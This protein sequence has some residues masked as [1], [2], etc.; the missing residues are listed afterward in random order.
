MGWHGNHCWR[1][2]Y[3]YSKAND[4]DGCLIE[5]A[6]AREHTFPQTKAN[7]NDELNQEVNNVVWANVTAGLEYAPQ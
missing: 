4:R 2:S 5:A 3:L 7:Q 6:S 1:A